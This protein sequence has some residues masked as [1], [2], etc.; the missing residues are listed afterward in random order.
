M[1]ES[2]KAEIDYT[3]VP[4]RSGESSGD[5]ASTETSAR[6]E[7]IRPDTPRAG[8]TWKYAWLYAEIVKA[9]PKRVTYRHQTRAGWE[10]SSVPT[11]RFME[12]FHKTGLSTLAAA[13]ANR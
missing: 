10:I 4:S 5:E 13:E 9:G 3:G 12:R 11:D 7:A 2:Q 6:P 8:E 1:S